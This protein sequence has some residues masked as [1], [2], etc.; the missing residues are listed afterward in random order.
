[1]FGWLKFEQRARRK[2]VKLD[3]THLEARTRRFLKAYLAADETRKPPFYHAV[4]DASAKCHPPNTDYQLE[5]AEMA[6]AT[7]RVAMKIVLARGKQSAAEE[8][9]KNSAFLTDAYAT[10]AVAYHRAAGAYVEDK[11]MQELGTAAVHLLTMATS[12]M[13]AQQDRAIPPE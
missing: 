13:M 3:R 2:T 1:V 5:D 9:G 8:D 12:Y 4:E 11:E 7:S 10:V 6:E